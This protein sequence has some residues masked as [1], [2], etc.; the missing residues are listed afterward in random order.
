MDGSLMYVSLKVAVL[1][2]EIEGVRL[3]EGDGISAREREIA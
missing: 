3:K 2:N 1:H